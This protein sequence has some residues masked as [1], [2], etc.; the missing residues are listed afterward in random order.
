MEQKVRF[1]TSSF[2]IDNYAV[3]RVIDKAI[4]IEQQFNGINRIV[5]IAHTLDNDV[6]LES[7]FGRLGVKKL[8]K[9]AKLPNSNATSYF[10]SKGTYRPRPNDIIIT[11]GLDDK[12]VFKIDNGSPSAKAIIAYPGIE[13]G[14]N[15]WKCN[16]NNID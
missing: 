7:Q 15:K 3:S 8:L 5:F 12:D 2:G 1:Y 14:I 6:W 10:H 4:Q 13:N 9:G 16:A 11:L